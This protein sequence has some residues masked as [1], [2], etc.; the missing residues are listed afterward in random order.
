MG[1]EGEVVL[2]ECEPLLVAVEEPIAAL[3]R[4]RCGRVARTPPP[5]PRGAESRVD[6]RALHGWRY[7]AAA[8]LDAGIVAVLL[9]VI[10]IAALTA[11]TVPVSALGPSAPALAIMALL[12][13]AAYFLCFG[14]L[15]GATVG[16]RTLGIEPGASPSTLTPRAVIDRALLSATEDVRCIQRCGERI[17]RSIAAWTSET[18]TAKG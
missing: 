3:A 11:M 15:R 18:G 1:F 17:G 14:G 16:E 10:V 12:L 13:G 6:A 4:L 7:V 2:A 9:L 5:T 8:A